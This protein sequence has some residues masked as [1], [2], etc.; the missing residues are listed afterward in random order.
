M[1]VGPFLLEGF[2]QK[3]DSFKVGRFLWHEEGISLTRRYASLSLFLSEL[4]NSARSSKSIAARMNGLKGV[5]FPANKINPLDFRLYSGFFNTTHICKDM[6]PKNCCVSVWMIYEFW[7]N[8]WPWSWP[9]RGFEVR[10]ASQHC[11]TWMAATNLLMKN[12]GLNEYF[13]F[14]ILL[15]TDYNFQ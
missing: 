15:N 9:F 5:H 4:W 1:A 2:A 13:I 8:S 12:M 10:S 3:P 7:S 14:V 6:I 11:S